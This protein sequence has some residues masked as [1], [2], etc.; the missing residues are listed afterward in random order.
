[1]HYRR[2]LNPTEV[3][4]REWEEWAMLHLT[5]WVVGGMI[6]ASFTSLLL[7]LFDPLAVLTRGI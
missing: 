2:I 1:M 6:G 3:H 7:Y 5:A 4:Q